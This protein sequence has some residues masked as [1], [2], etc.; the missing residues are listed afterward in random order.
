[1][2]LASRSN[3]VR[4]CASLV[5]AAGRTLMATVRSRRVSRAFQTSPIPPAPRGETIS[6]GP[7]RVPDF[8]D[9]RIGAVYGAVR[10]PQ[11]ERAA[12][13]PLRWPEPSRAGEDGVAQLR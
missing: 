10:A 11:P 7:R 8:T 13:A 12:S 3:R 2:V 1:M 6:Y 5:R 4:K 9:I